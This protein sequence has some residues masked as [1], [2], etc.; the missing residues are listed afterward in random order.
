M[1]NYITE[2]EYLKNRTTINQIDFKNKL[3]IK[4]VDR[5]L[6]PEES[7][8]FQNVMRKLQNSPLLSKD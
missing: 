3:K 2:H 5:Y 4:K 1:K 8:K 7:I 6:I